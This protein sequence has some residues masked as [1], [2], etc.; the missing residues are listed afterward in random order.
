MSTSRVDALAHS[1]P[2]SAPQTTIETLIYDIRQRGELA[3]R[4]PV[5]LY[6]ITELSALQLEEVVLRLATRCPAKPEGVPAH[7]IAQFASMARK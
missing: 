4:D 5:N 6:R 2:K 3:L 7:V 1:H